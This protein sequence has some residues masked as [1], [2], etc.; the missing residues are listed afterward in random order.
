MS[1][2]G[3]ATSFKLDIHGH[4]VNTRV[5]WLTETMSRVTLILESAQSASYVPSYLAIP[6]LYDNFNYLRSHMYKILSLDSRSIN[7]QDGSRYGPDKPH[8]RNKPG[9]KYR[10]LGAKHLPQSSLDWCK[11]REDQGI[12]SFRFRLCIY[13]PSKTWPNQSM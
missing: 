9:L 4:V 3:L 12:P 10:R 13:I 6:D 7:S 2:L 11:P 5:V 8:C 1:S